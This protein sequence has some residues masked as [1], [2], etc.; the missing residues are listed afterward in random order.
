MKRLR[1]RLLKWIAGKDFTVAERGPWH[2]NDHSFT[3]GSYAQ[4]IW[5]RK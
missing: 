4:V 5:R 1:L 2:V 3:T